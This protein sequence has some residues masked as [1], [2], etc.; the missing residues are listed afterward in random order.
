MR[1]ACFCVGCAGEAD[2]RTAYELSL[3]E[4]LHFERRAFHSLFATKDQKEGAL[5]GFRVTRTHDH[6][7][8]SRHG[9]VCGEEEAVVYT[10]MSC[11]TTKYV[12]CT[13]YEEA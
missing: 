10:Y 12:E 5:I 11:T 2:A 3:A 4:G 9:C 8:S 7:C 1:G 6:A 13:R